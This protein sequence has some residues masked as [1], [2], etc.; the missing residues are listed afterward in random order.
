[1]RFSVPTLNRARSMLP[2]LVDPIPAPQPH[3]LPRD[4]SPKRRMTKNNTKGT[5]GKHMEF[6]RAKGSYMPIKPKRST[7]VPRVHT[8]RTSGRAGDKDGPRDVK[9]L[10]ASAE[11]ACR[12]WRRVAEHYAVTNDRPRLADARGELS[13]CQSQ[14]DA[15]ASELL[16]LESV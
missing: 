4:K 1:M 9:P 14:R 16:L 11:A 13:R 2:A 10:L 6:T 7:N 5:K 15:L 8:G 12:T 3:A